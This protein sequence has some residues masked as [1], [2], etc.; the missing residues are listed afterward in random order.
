VNIIEAR[1]EE[2]LSMVHQEIKRS[3]VSG[4]TACWVD[5][6]RRGSQLPGNA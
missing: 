4:L 2:I 3:G 1:A 6:D 5:P